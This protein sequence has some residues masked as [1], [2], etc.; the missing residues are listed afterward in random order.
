MIDLSPAAVAA[1]DFYDKHYACTDPIILESGKTK[2]TLGSA[3][4][5]RCCRFC[6]KD[7]SEVT[8]KD[9]AHALPAAFGNTGLFSNY[10]CDVCNHLFGE[11]IENHLGNWSKPMRTLS[12]IK[13][14][15]GVPTIKEQ[16]ADKGWRVQ[17]SGTG[18]HLTEYEDEP[19]FAIDEDARKLRFELHRD[20]YIPVSALK[21]LVKIGLTLIPDAE[22][23][24]FIETFDWI[25]DADHSRNFVSEFPMLRTVIPG[26][27][28]NDL[29]TLMLLRRRDGI[30]T[31]PYAFFIFAYGNEV[32]QV[33][34]PSISQDR[35]IDGKSLTM[36]AF[37]T[38]GSLDPARFGMPSVTVEC[39]T[40]WAPVKGEKVPVVFSFDDIEQLK[41]GTGADNT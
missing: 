20:T 22:T 36:P 24:H 1:A 10:E 40:G 41:S 2:L 32:L 26:P 17:Y 16:G 12:R 9:K 13:G 18:F 31:V 14:R 28:R 8:F 7:E 39:L 5:P 19:F 11:G 27:M 23:Q 33:F 29:I 37:P 38:P 4:R 35:C 3:E 25:R 34:L 30:D 6:G 15:N 21:G